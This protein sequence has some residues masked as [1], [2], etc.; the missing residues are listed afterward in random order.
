MREGLT[1]IVGMCKKY[2]IVIGIIL[3]IIL[4]AFRPDT[5][6]LQSNGVVW[7]GKQNIVSQSTAENI[8][9]PCFDALHFNAGVKEQKVNFYNPEINSCYMNMSI[10]LADG[11]EIWSTNNIAPGY[12][13]YDIVLNEALES[14]EYNNSHFV[15][16]C[17]DTETDTEM[18][19]AN[20]V[21]NLYVNKG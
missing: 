10:E 14:G 3:A 5:T 4:W 8:C 9:I 6:S 16:R 7:N 12:G 15:V 17:F 21:F 2:L 1:V 11:T 18:N 19:G 13:V 20:I